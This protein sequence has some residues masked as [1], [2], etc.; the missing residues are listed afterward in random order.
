MT[1]L[2]YHLLGRSGLRVSELAL[3]TMTFGPDWGW[4]ADL[5]ECRRILDRFVEVGGNFVDTASNYTDGSSE[6][7]V[8][9]LVEGRRDR[10]VLAT[11]YTLSLDPHDPNAGGNHRKSLVRALD[12]ALEQEAQA[13]GSLELEHR[14]D[15]FDPLPGLRRIG[16]PVDPGIGCHRG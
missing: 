9:E 10:F 6:S 15:R 11:K 4:G 5:D 16:V 8:G 7:F 12:H 14:V 13:V 1:S 2:R 3:G